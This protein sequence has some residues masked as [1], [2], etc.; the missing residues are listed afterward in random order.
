MRFLDGL[1]AAL[2]YVD[3]PLPDVLERLAV[4]DLPGDARLAAVLAD[5][6]EWMREDRSMGFADALDT[7]RA[8]ADLDSTDAAALLPLIRELGGTARPQQTARID[9]AR[10][11]LKAQAAQASDRTGRQKRL[12]VSLGSLGGLALFL[13]LIG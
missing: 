13:C 8:F 1:A 11:A 2:G 9:S 4:A 10:A 12:F 5:A 6:A 7:E 3:D